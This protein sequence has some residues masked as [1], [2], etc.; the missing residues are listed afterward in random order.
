MRHQLAVQLTVVGMQDK[1][2]ASGAK[3]PSGLTALQEIVPD[4]GDFE[5]VVAFLQRLLQ[6]DP[7]CRPTARQALADPFFDSIYGVA[8]HHGK[9]TVCDSI[10]WPHLGTAENPRSSML[11]S[12]ACLACM[13][14]LTVQ[15]CYRGKPKAFACCLD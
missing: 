12:A 13:S 9:Q 4:C 2:Y 11:C 8:R 1:D 6:I 7:S 5:L 10:E 3:V 14:C 15:P